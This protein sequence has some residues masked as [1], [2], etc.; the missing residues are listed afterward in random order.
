ML[1]QNFKV[2]WID[3]S[4]AAAMLQL[5]TKTLRRKVV[6]GYFGRE[7]HYTVLPGRTYMY[8][9]YDIERYLLMN[10]SYLINR[11]DIDRYVTKNQPV[12]IVS[13]KCYCV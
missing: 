3:E 2:L 6:E 13:S 7:I 11:Q 10:S 8:N 9:K 1:P 4:E 12:K 5:Q